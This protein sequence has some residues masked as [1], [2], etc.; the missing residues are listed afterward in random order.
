MVDGVMVMRDGQI[1]T[2]DEAA[3]KAEARELMREQR[4][5]L[6]RAAEHAR[7]LEPYYRAMYLRAA[8]SDVGMQRWMSD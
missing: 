6:Q 4:P 3:I 2:I 1:L 7:A 8:M 5:M